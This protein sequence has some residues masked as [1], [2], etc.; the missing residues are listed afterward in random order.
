VTIPNRVF[1]DT[2][3]PTAAE[4]EQALG[5]KNWF[6]GAFL[7]DENSVY[8]LRGAAV[9]GGLLFLL[10]TF[11]W[12]AVTGG[13]YDSYVFFSTLFLLLVLLSFA[14]SAFA[15]FLDQPEVALALLGTA[16]VAVILVISFWYASLAGV[17][18][19]AVPALWTVG[20]G[21]L[22]VG[23]T[24]AVRISREIDSDE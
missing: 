18:A 23:S 12:L 1:S 11:Y 24:E 5:P 14:G 3:Y 10:G 19:F 17:A 7:W 21:L 22:A 4:T 6:S 15:A 2:T 9:F 16:G 8:A 20:L 13:N